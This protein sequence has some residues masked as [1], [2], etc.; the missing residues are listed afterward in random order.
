MRI[1]SALEPDN[2]YLN[3]DVASTWE[4]LQKFRDVDPADARDILAP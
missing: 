1:K 2:E 3:V 4:L